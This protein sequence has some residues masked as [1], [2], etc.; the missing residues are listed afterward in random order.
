[1]TKLVVHKTISFAILFLDAI[2]NGQR[3]TLQFIPTDTFDR[4]K[5]TIASLTSKLSK[6]LKIENWDQF[7]AATFVGV[8]NELRRM[9][10]TNIDTFK[11]NANL[12]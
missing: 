8:T 2:R 5:E 11:S 9:D 3:Q 6:L 4:S 12:Q 1:M 10:R 7:T